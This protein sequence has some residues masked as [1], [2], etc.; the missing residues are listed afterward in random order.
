MDLNESLIEELEYD[1]TDAGDLRNRKLYEQNRKICAMIVLGQQTDHGLALLTK[2]KGTGYPHGRANLFLSQMRTRYT[3]NDTAAEMELDDALERVGMKGANDYFNKCTSIQ[4]K[5]DVPCSDTKLIKMMAKK[6][7]SDTFSATIIGHLRQSTPD[8][9]EAVCDEINTL[10]R[11]TGA[12]TSVHKAE[13]EVALA[14][15]AKGNNGGFKGK[16]NNCGRCCITI[17]W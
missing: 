1:L 7:K 6:V 12:T 3:L 2:M 15:Y 11:M 4:A 5:F 13:K 17:K 9:F 14:N 16:C 10:Q 8:D